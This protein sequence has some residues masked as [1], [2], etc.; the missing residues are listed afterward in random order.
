M[1]PV[2]GTRQWLGAVLT[3]LAFRF[4]IGYELTH[5]VQGHLRLHMLGTNQHRLDEVP[6][7]VLGNQFLRQ[8]LEVGADRGGLELLLADTSPWMFLHELVPHPEQ[9][10]SQSNVERFWITVIFTVFRLLDDGR[11]H[12]AYSEAS[13]PQPVLRVLL[14]YYFCASQLRRE[15]K[16]EEIQA[17]AEHWSLAIAESRKAFALL[18]VPEANRKS[19]LESASLD[20][21]AYASHLNEAWLNLIPNLRENAVPNVFLSEALLDMGH[22]A[23]DH[24]LL[25]ERILSKTPSEQITALLSKG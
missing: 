10:M 22:L 7:T 17:F 21:I 11:K 4:V 16:L 20:K 5:V 23:E 13:H 14:A 9:Y 6:T 25:A 18:G 2:D 1:M 3:R 19:L 24:A 15:G 12:G 8:A